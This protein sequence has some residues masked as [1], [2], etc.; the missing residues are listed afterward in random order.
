VIEY[1]HTDNY[2]SF[3]T[4]STE[5]MRIDSSGNVGINTTSPSRKFSIYD[6]SAIP[7]RVE[8]NTSDNKIEI[9]TSSGT[10][11]VQGSANNLLFGTNNIERI[12]IDSSGNVGIGTGSPTETLEVAGDVLIKDGS[13]DVNIYLGNDNY[14]FGIDYSTG[15]ISIKTNNATR[16]AVLN[17]GNVGIGTTS[18]TGLLTVEGVTSSNTVDIK[19]GSEGASRAIRL[20][21]GGTAT[22]YNWLVGA[23]YNINNAFEITPSTAVGGTTFSSANFVVLQN[24][25]IGT[26]AD[27]D[28]IYDASSDKRVKKKIKTISGGLDSV[29]KLNP[30]TFEWKKDHKPEKEGDTIY[31]FIAQELQE[32]IPEAVYNTGNSSTINGQEVEDILNIKKEYILPVLVKAIQEQQKEIEYLKS[33]IK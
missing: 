27:T 16:I 28:V 13:N 33:K 1:G 32:V 30:V 25:D 14:G 29:M 12:R 10:Q 8:T 23:Q 15:D 20:L 26:G 19:G 31:G 18:P 5:R 4:A 6:T 22:K 24:G 11:F 3:K 17:G 9:I 7:M 2:M 21:D